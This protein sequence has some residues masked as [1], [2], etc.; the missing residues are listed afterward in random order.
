MDSV[1]RLFYVLYG[2][3]TKIVQERMN[4][5]NIWT[6]RVASRGGRSKG[7]FNQKIPLSGCFSHGARGKRCMLWPM[8]AFHEDPELPLT[9]RP[10]WLLASA[11]P[12]IHRPLA[13]YR[14]Y[15]RLCPANLSHLSLL[16]PEESRQR[17]VHKMCICRSRL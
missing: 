12:P 11:N 5:A 6:R 13:C 2:L 15:S 17:Y 3:L 7:G 9:S 4:R 16:Q 10:P 1:T 14:M 8:L